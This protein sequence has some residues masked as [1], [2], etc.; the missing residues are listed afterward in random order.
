MRECFIVPA[1]VAA[2]VGGVCGIAF[3]LYLYSVFVL[4]AP[5]GL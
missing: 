3:V 5:H 2:V 1:I 4:G